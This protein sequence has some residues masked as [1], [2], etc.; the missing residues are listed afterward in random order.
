MKRQKSE[1]EFPLTEECAYLNSASEGPMPESVWKVFMDVAGKKKRPHALK[2]KEYFNIPQKT[3]ENC[4]ELIGADS[5]NIALTRSTSYGI[6][7]TARGLDLDSGDKVVLLCDQFPCIVYPWMNLENKD[8]EIEFVSYRDGR[9]P[10]E[11]IDPKAEVL[12]MSYVNFARGFKADLEEIVSF[13]DTN[14]IVTVMDVTQGLGVLDE[15]PA[16]KGINVIACSGHKWLLSPVGTGFLYIEEDLAERIK[17]PFV[18]WF[19]LVKEG[20]FDSLVDYDFTLPEEATRYEIGS[21][22]LPELAAFSASV[23]FLLNRGMGGIQ[24]HVFSLL[25]ELIHFLREKNISIESS[26]GEGRRSGILSFSPEDPGEVHQQLLNKDI[27]TS[28]REGAIRISPHLFNTSEDI[29]KVIDVL[30]SD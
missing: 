7:V 28:L 6:N 5:Q 14:G 4:A 8:I 10:V 29:K 25:D 13:C 16:R 27:I 20:N 12:A 19:S 18:G 3:R 15:K 21:H 1:E 24:D 17:A 11:N 30:K 9:I 22:P 26:T 2:R 23:E